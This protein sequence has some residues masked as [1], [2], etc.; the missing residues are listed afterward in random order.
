MHVYQLKFAFI[1]KFTEIETLII[2]YTAF[3]E[4]TIYTNKELLSPFYYLINYLH[5]LVFRR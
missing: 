5:L 4:T 3:C 1:L 2:S